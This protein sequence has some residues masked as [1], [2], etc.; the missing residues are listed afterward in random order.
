MRPEAPADSERALASVIPSVAGVP[1]YGAVLISLVFTVIGSVIAG[2]NYDAGVPVVL[3]IFFLAGTILAAL[4]VRRH[5]VFTA[6]VQPPL[7]AAVVVFVGAK[8]FAGE[9][10]L[11]AAVNVVKIFP[12]MLVATGVAVA[13][14]LVRIAT[15]RLRST[16]RPADR[17]G[18]APEDPREV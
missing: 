13:I 8:I 3:W 5:S 7:I 15:T 11:S 17:T 1:W 6:M 14:G 12:M 10:T 4:A 16:D 9:Q 2:S 18:A